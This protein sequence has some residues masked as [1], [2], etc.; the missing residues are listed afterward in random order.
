MTTSTFGTPQRTS[1]FAS[2]LKAALL[3][4]SVTLRYM[5]VA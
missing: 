3:L 2:R 5:I 4:Y 1:T